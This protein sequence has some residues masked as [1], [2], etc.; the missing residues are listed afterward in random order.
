MSSEFK[1]ILWPK[2]SISS[3]V[4][5]HTREKQIQSLMPMCAHA[6][7]C[8]ILCNPTDFSHQSPLSI[9]IPRQEYWSRLPFP[10]PGLSSWL[11]DQIQSLASPVLQAYS[12]ALS[13]WGKWRRHYVIISSFQ[14]GY[15]VPNILYLSTHLIL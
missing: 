14:S 10:S 5:T 8:L 4:D 2:N 7:T 9:E 11:R 3:R 13:R 12:S 15:Y 1:I 6:Q